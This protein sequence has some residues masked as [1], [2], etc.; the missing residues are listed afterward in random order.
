MKNKNLIAN[1][2]LASIGVLALIFL[3]LPHLGGLFAISGYNCFEFLSSLGM[4]DFR[5]AIIYIAP[6]V[7][8]IAGLVI[9]AFS[10]LN[11]LGN[12]NIIKSETLLKV[13]RILNLIA[14]IVLTLF[15]VLAFV[16]IITYEASLGAGLIINL[17]LG[18]V[19]IV[20]SA[21]VLVWNKK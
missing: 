8:L 10:A 21:L 12:L 3:A 20:G 1:I 18:V 19:A 4:M 17:V 11:I 14:S 13:S 15:A 9:L 6:L 2:C 5:T 16:F 7:I